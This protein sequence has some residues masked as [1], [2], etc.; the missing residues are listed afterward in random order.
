VSSPVLWTKD[1]SVAFGG[2]KAVNNVSLGI[3]QGVFTT[4]IGPN[5]AGKTSLFNLLSGLLK[6]TSGQIYMQGAEITRLS[7]TARVALGLGRSFQLTN[8]FPALTVQENIRLA[9]QSRFRVGIK[10]F[11]PFQSYTEIN[12]AVERMLLDVRLVDKRSHAAAHLTHSEQR[13]LELAMVLSLE[14][15]VLLLD[16]PTAGMALED[17][18][19]MFELLSAVKRKAGLTTV[20]IEHKMELVTSLSDRVVVLASGAIIASGTPGEVAQNP[21]VRASYLGGGNFVEA[22]A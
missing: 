20:L 14:P 13:K 4:I 8:L 9:V 18:P 22:G 3:E 15:K 6:P 2:H 1:L 11:R 12:E 5:G 21:L 17:V 10:L 7:P 16:E 19:A